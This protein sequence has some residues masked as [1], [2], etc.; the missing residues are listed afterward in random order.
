MKSNLFIISILSV[1]FL[2]GCSTRSNGLLPD[3]ATFS[4]TK[5]AKTALVIGSIEEA[6]ITI[7]HA[8]YV[9]IWNVDKSQQET[10]MVPTTDVAQ[11]KQDFSDRNHLGNYF[12]FEVKEGEYKLSQWDYRYYRDKSEELQ[13]PIV[14]KFEKGKI[15]YIGR[16]FSNALTMNLALRDESQNDI[17]KIKEKYTNFPEQE[18]IN[19]S[20]SHLFYDWKLIRKK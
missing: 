14:Y 2:S 13:P 19:L 17:V 4:A 5:E 18:V 1:L 8:A 20:Q 16:F 10:N 3:N 15:Y 12:V 11:R 6:Y 7:P 9:C